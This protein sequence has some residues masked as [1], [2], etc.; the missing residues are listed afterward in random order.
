MILTASLHGQM[1]SVSE[2]LARLKR[3]LH[4]WEFIWKKCCNM[5]PDVISS[6]HEY[7][8]NVALRCL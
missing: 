4:V 6:V 8:S 1:A 3:K 5:F 2:W 7:V